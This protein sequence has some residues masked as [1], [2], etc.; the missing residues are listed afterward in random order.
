MGDSSGES[1][2]SDQYV[3]PVNVVPTQPLQDSSNAAKV[4]TGY[5][6]LTV[7]GINFNLFG[8]FFDPEAAF[9]YFKEKR[10][11]FGRFSLR[12]L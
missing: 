5:K 9:L 7:D 6:L 4:L 11:F 3:P 1:S 8:N 2:D 10:N 12:S